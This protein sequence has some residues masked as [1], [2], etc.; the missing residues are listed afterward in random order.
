MCVF[1]FGE[2]VERNDQEGLYQIKTNRFKLVLAEADEESSV[3]KQI[4]ELYEQGQKMK[5]CSVHL[6]SS[7]SQCECVLML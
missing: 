7:A 6:N 1:F 2:T 5:V 3:R 4:E